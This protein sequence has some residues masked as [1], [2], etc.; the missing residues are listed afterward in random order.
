MSDLISVI[1][2]I[3]NSEKYIRSCVDSILSQTHKSLEVI[4]VDDGSSDKSASICDEYKDLD[5]RVIVLHKQNEGLIAA[6]KDGFRLSRGDWVAFVDSDDW[7]DEE[8]VESLYSIAIKESSEL[9]ISGVIDESGTASKI[10]KNQIP[11]GSYAGE[12]LDEIKAILFGGTDYF[13]FI[14]LPYLWNKLWKRSILDDNLEAVDKTIR[15]GEDV[16]IGFPAIIQA[17]CIS[18]IDEAFYHYRQNPTSMLMQRN[19]QELEYKNAISMYT[20]L[21][22]R[23]SEIGY[24]DITEN[25]IRRLYINLIMTRAYG[26]VSQK[27]SDYTLFP[28]LK[29]DD[30][31]IIVYGAGALGLSVYNYAKDHLKVKFWVDRNAEFMQTLGYSVI[32]PDSV[33]FK[34]DDVVVVTIFDMKAATSVKSYLLERGVDESNILLFEINDEQEIDLLDLSNRII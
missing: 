20:Y 16:A 17:N 28:F 2:P 30:L 3:Y 7:I 31:E 9:V 1:V 12:K 19:N 21:S 27:M 22:H 5:N 34:P 33:E 23:L 15:V 13:S 24:I 32:A 14:I 29:K 4:L 8:F 25:G 10:R 18:V 11:R 6:R 26:I